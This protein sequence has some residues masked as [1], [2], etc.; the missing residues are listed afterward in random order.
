MEHQINNSRAYAAFC[1][2]VNIWFGEREKKIKLLILNLNN[3]K[4][5]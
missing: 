4:I 1:S 3:L 2:Q 5:F